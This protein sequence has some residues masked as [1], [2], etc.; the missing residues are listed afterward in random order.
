MSSA[1][2]QMVDELESGAQFFGTTLKSMEAEIQS[3]HSARML[4]DVVAPSLGFVEIEILAVG[5]QAYMKF[6]KDAQWLPLPL[7]QV[8][9]NFGAVGV[10]LSEVLPIMKNV[11]ITGRESLG[12]A[13]TIRVDGNIVSEELSDLITSVD[14]GHLITLT[15]WLD[16]VEHTLRQLRIAGKIFDAD[17][18]GTKRLVTISG[19]NVPVDI[20]VPGYSRRT[21]NAAKSGFT[22]LGSSQSVVLGILCLGVFSTAL[23]QTVV[24]AAL[25]SVMVDL[26]IPLTD[27][28]RASWIVTGYLIA[29]TVAMP[30]AGRLSD[31]HGRVRMFQA[32]LV[33]FSIGSALV[34]VAP[35]F[36]W[37]V[38]ARVLQ[39]IGGGATVPIGLAMAVGVVAPEKRGIA[40]GTRGRLG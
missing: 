12:G 26:E 37:I 5:D 30:L 40:L 1:K 10:T 18:P 36:S 16:E 24:V 39:A 32:A 33:L 29:Y 27:L 31:V 21:V 8:S 34:A 35:D 25:P 13:Q 19:L 2:L 23:D 4:V 28:D 6:S 22:S 15:F 9:F 3:P 11:A 17:A 20:Q 7:E 14:S 38:S